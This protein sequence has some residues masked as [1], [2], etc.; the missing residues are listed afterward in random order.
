MSSL[1]HNVRVNC[2]KYW[3]DQEL[4]KL[5]SRAISSQREWVAAGKPHLGNI[6]EIREKKQILL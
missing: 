2:L 5:K 4:N 1:K 6:A 3:W